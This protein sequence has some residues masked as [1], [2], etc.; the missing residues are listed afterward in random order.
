LQ[1]IDLSIYG[2]SQKKKNTPGKMKSEKVKKKKT[3]ISS[4]VTLAMKD[5]E[6]IKL[7]L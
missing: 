7:H 4:A 2:F 1:D 3:S 5:T 6:L